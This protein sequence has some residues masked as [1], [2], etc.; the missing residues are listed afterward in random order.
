M[1]ETSGITHEKVVEAYIGIRNKMA[2]AD[3]AMKKWK[4][5]QTKNQDKLIEYFK[6]EQAN[7]GTNSFKTNAGTAYEDELEFINIAD[8]PVFMDFIM[9][10][11]LMT[12]WRSRY[13]DDAGGWHENGEQL[14]INDKSRITNCGAFDFL[15]IS[16]KK[17]NC[18]EYMNENDGVLPA[19]LKYTK[20]KTFKF[21]A[22]AKRKDK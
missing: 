15:S 19:G 20:E 9:N 10:Q 3:K 2:A 1:S 11:I 16:A 4:E 14:L 7:S 21:R 22:S 5:G 18:I 8:R 12:V 17:V 6:K 13:T